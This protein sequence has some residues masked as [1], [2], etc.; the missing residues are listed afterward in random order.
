MAIN[1]QTATSKGT[2]ALGKQR[3]YNEVV[4]YLD[5]H[6]SKGHVDT[7]LS[8]IVALDKAFNKPSASIKTALVGGTNGKSLTINFAAKLMIEEKMRVGA[9]YNPHILSYNERFVVD[10]ESISNKTFT[11]LANDVI[12]TAETLGIKADTFEILTMMALLYFKQSNVDL[13]L[14]EMYQDS[15]A[16]PTNVCHPIIYAITRV[17]NEEMAPHSQETVETIKKMVS[18]VKTGTHVV[19]GDQSKLNL[20]VIADAVAERGG[21]WAM[22]IRK[23][24]PLAYPFEQ[25]HGR[26]AALAER[27]CQ[28]YVDN[29]VSKD[30]VIVANSLLAREKGQ[31]GRPTLE[32]KR[33]SEL[34]PKQTLEQFWREESSALAGRFQ[35]LDK[36]KPT[37]LLDNA[38]NIDALKN[39]LLGIRLL[40]Y[41][42]P[43]KGLTFIFGCDKN[44]M[45]VEEFLR[46]L[47]YFTKKNSAQVIFCP[48]T[49]SVP[50]VHEESW[51]V[52]QITNDV[53]S[54]KIKA[55]SA[56]NFEDAFEQAKKTV[57]ERNGLVVIAGSQSIV[58]E[59][60]NYKG[61]KK[62]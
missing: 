57:D 6:W 39:L 46:L 49:S 25:L 45:H 61:I 26:C 14:L 42:R 60:W 27:I 35:V 13:A 54:L 5:A 33:Q 43:L 52:E 48:I 21:H 44:E 58:T 55:K 31:R 3:S 2:V 17:T 8:N 40:H 23:L 59:F 47:R 32:A 22:P 41:Q 10:N 1:K 24:A 9:F 56:K 19:S 20:Q 34:N 18:A 36:E 11:E 15:P 7:K 53:K 30:A 50:G 37:V 16:D 4:E 29:F 51:N 62:I 38:S 12:N 28:I